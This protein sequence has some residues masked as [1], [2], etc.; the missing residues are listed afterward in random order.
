MKKR[1]LVLWTALVLL[2][3]GNAPAQVVGDFNSLTYWGTGANQSALVVN[4][5]DGKTNQVLAWGFRW[6]GPAPTVGDMLLSLAASDPRLFVRLDSDA[7]YGIALFGIGYQTG[8]SP[9]GVTGAQDALGDNVVPSFVAGLND[10]NTTSGNTDAPWSSASAA[11]LNSGDHYSEA[12]NSP[13]RYWT[14]FLSGSD[15]FPTTATASLTYPSAWSEAG[16]GL[17]GVTLDNNAW[18]ALSYSDSGYTPVTPGSAVAAVPE[19]GTV[20][21]FLLSTGIILA[22]VYR[23]KFCH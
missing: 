1:L 23:R 17:S 19:P 3:A 9:F 15:L 11:P 6:D 12:W 14:L 18:Y 5:N 13:D 10:M 7:S 8:A 4:W 21:L 16:A 20:T 2:A 22:A